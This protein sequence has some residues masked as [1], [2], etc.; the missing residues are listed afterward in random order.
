MA[1]KNQNQQILEL[2]NFLASKGIDSVEKL[3]SLL[4]R[5]DKSSSLQNTLK[6]KIEETGLRVHQLEVVRS[7]ANGNN[8]YVGYVAEGTVYSKRRNKEIE[9]NKDRIILRQYAGNRLMTISTIP[10]QDVNTITEL[11]S[12]FQEGN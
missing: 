9:Y 10:I 3:V 8:Y 7:K 6:A 12:K 5:E 4:Q 11:L 1:K 2:A